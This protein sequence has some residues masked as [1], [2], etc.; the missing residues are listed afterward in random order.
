MTDVCVHC[1]RDANLNASPERLCA[2]HMHN[3]GARHHPQGDARDDGYWFW[4]GILVSGLLLFGL[5]WVIVGVADA[6]FQA[7]TS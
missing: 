4:S 1:G 5:L 2:Y 7:V 3:P 6:I